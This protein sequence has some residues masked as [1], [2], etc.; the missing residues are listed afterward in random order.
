MFFLRKKNRPLPDSARGEIKPEYFKLNFFSWFLNNSALKLEKV[1]FYILFLFLR[2][3]VD[4][5]VIR[6]LFPC[7]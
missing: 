4:G 7:S 2:D 5:L 3:I 6:L 1:R